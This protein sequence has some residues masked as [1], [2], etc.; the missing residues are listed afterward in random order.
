MTFPVYGFVSSSAEHDFEDGPAP[1][2]GRK[3]IRPHLRG[4]YGPLLQQYLKSCGPYISGHCYGSQ[5]PRGK[6]YWNNSLS[7]N[8][9]RAILSIHGQLLLSLSESMICRRLVMYFFHRPALRSHD[10]TFHQL[11]WALETFGN[12]AQ[13][14]L[15]QLQMRSRVELS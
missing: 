7:F 14:I 6:Y 9:P 8:V 11:A 13:C 3:A 12:R 2:S 5:P 10:H 4:G 15:C 1:A